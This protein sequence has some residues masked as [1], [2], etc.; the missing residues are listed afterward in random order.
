VTDGRQRVAMQALDR[1]MHAGGRLR[2]F[3]EHIQKLRQQQR[4][5]GAVRGPLAAEISILPQFPSFAAA[6]LENCVPNRS[7]GAFVVEHPEDQRL[8]RECAPP[9]LPRALTREHTLAKCSVRRSYCHALETP[10][11]T[12]SNA[13]VV[14]D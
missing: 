14:M 5:R 6:A 3:V 2:Q 10:Q 11:G 4:F 9:V 12:T 8:I 13:C 7:W 1:Y